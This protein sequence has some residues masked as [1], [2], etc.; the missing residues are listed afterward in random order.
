MIGIFSRIKALFTHSAMERDMDVEMRVHLDMLADEYQ[1]SGMPRDEAQRK[2]RL[3]FGN[4]SQIK[5]RSRDIRGA[6]L[7]GDL[8]QDLRYA[9]RMFWRTPLVSGVIVL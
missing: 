9:V 6:G 3:R 5:D 7:L 8:V 2:A 1:Q 4:V